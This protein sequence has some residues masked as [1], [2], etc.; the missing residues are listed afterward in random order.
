M[1]I[2]LDD[3]QKYVDT[4]PEPAREE[5]LRQNWPLIKLLYERE[6][7]ASDAQDS[8]NHENAIQN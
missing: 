8:G 6:K 4:L 2:T 7:E 5:Y 1:R 3:I